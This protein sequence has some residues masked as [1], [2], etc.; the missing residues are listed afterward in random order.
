MLLGRAPTVITVIPPTPAPSAQNSPTTA[1]VPA[2]ADA[3]AAAAGDDKEVGMF[4][5]VA[6]DKIELMSEWLR[7]HADIFTHLS[8]GLVDVASLSQDALLSQRKSAMRPC[9]YYGRPA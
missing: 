2:P 5:Q 8:A 1:A 4:Q 3:A 9:S 6:D 7:H